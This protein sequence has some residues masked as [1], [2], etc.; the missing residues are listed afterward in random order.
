MPPHGDS[1]TI[2]LGTSDQEYFSGH[3]AAHKAQQIYSATSQAVFV[4]FVLSA[5]CFVSIAGEIA[6]SGRGS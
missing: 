1:R 2:A 6:P 5:R 4:C 3:S